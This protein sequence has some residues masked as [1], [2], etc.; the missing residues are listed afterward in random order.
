MSRC[1]LLSFVLVTLLVAWVF[2]AS[3][4]GQGQI[5][6]N[7]NPQGN[8]IELGSGSNWYNDVQFSNYGDLENSGTLL[9]SRMLVTY[10]GLTNHGMFENGDEIFNYGGMLNSGTFANVAKGKLTNIGTLTHNG[11]LINTGEMTNT[12]AVTSNGTLTNEFGGTLTN[13]GTFNN[14]GT[15]TN[16]GTLMTSGT[17]NN[18]G[19]LNG[20]GIVSGLFTDLGILAPGN[21][22]GVLTFSGNLIKTGGSLEIELGGIFDG[23][24]DKSLTEFDWLDVSGVFNIAGTLD[25]Q[26]INDFQLDELYT[27]EIINLDGKLTGQFDGL[28]EGDVVGNFGGVDLFITYA[29]GDG[30]DVVLFNN[31]VSI[32][33]PGAV[34]LLILGLGWFASRRRQRTMTQ[35]ND[36]IRERSHNGTIT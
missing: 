18:N 3:A 22:A 19:T 6:P 26:L 1:F 12:G 27:F 29:G 24:G 5:S 28:G 36:H 34:G 31:L 14:D 21:S 13:S 7:P 30:N 10:G 15:V 11:M 2:P 23:G 4:V 33:E 9:N 17:F 35:G 20:D 16:N 32:P 8:T 25:V